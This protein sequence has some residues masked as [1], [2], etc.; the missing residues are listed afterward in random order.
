MIV[1]KKITIT[2]PLLVV[3]IASAV[4]LPGCIN[5]EGMEQIGPIP[6]NEAPVAIISTSGT[7]DSAPDYVDLTVIDA[8][9][10]A[11][12]LIT[13][14]ASDSHDSDGKIVSY[15]WIW[16]DNSDSSGVTAT[17]QFYIDNI[18][19]L[20]GLPLIFSIIL[21]IEDDDQY[22]TLI[23]YRLGVIPKKHTFYLDSNGL[24]LEKLSAGQNKIKP[25]FGKLRPIEELNYELEESIFLQPC[26][27]NVIVYFEKP[28]FSI[29]NKISIVLYDEEGNKLTQKEGSLGL[30]SLWKEKTIEMTGSFNTANSFKSVKMIVYGISL[31]DKTYILHGGETASHISFDFAT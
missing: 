21:N 26:N 9:A 20:Q 5:K 22:S 8:V 30:T 11:G 15:K 18:F 1:H 23:E 14:D 2:I 7:V 4:L 6:K 3:F 19:D 31:R 27:W 17:R 28:L 12:D 29:V 24:N 25:S 13:F 16:E 10:Y